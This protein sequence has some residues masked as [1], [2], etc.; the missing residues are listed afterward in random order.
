MPPGNR[1]IGG[2]QMPAFEQILWLLKTARMG[3]TMPKVKAIR[4]TLLA[5]W[6]IKATRQEET[7]TAPSTRLRLG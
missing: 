1:Q 2:D 3:A 6:P 5:E 4:S 7:Q